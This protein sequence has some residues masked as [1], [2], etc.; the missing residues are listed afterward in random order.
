MGGLARYL[1]SSIGLSLLP[2]VF[3][4]LALFGFLSLAEELEDVGKGDF[5]ALDAITVVG[6]SLPNLVLDLLPVALLLGA[7]VGLGGLANHSELIAAR[8]AGRSP[9][10]LLVP[11]ML[12][13]LGLALLFLL[14]GEYLV[15]V[16][17][18]Q[19]GQ[20]RAKALTD[21]SM[22]DDQIWTRTDQQIVKIGRLGR[23]G[24]LNDVEIFDY[25][26]GQLSS[27]RQAKAAEVI[28]QGH[29]RLEDVLV[30]LHN[31]HSA[32]QTQLS[33]ELWPISLPQDKLA[34]LAIPPESLGME[35]LRDRI[36]RALDNDL[37]V[38]GLR[39]M[40]WQRLSLPLAAVAMIML[41]LPFVMGSTRLLS[42]GERV[43]YGVLAGLTF[44]LTEQFCAHLAIILRINPVVMAV[45]PEVIVTVLVG[46]WLYRTHVSA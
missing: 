29:W 8:A 31:E 42:A 35:D 40:M 41:S 10:Q 32:T 30:L 36:L 25:D 2:V 21:F 22:E 26:A 16:A 28:D 43:T 3:L 12:F 5:E 44:Y 6:L 20:L 23:D 27:V 15:P 46:R 19:A 17:E 45:A 38:H 9:L 4:L 37:D 14:M 39:V 13:G 24:M 7:L 18:Q 1:V 11:P 34:V 33:V